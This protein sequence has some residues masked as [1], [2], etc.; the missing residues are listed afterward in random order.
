MPGAIFPNLPDT[1]IFILVILISYF[2]ELTNQAFIAMKYRH[3]KIKFKYDRLSLL[4]I[5]LCSIFSIYLVVAIGIL[6]SANNLG[7]LPPYFFYI[8]ISIMVIGEAI[9]QWSIYT[10]GKFFTY[11]VIIAAD[12]KLITKGPYRIVRHPGYLGGIIFAAG[13]GIAVQSFI[14]PLVTIGIICLAYAYRIYLEEK[15]LKKAF[16]RH[17]FEYSKKTPMLLPRP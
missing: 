17:Y 10:L 5:D 14:A 9:R 6:R 3:S 13:L 11:P 8:G 16:G 4:A 2:I 1:V 12:H 15:I 7:Y